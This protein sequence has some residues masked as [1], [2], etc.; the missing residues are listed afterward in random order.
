M[1]DSP[2]NDRSLLHREG[3]AIGFLL[4]A[5][6]L[7]YFP[8]LFGNKTVFSSDTAFFNFPMYETL[9]RALHEGFIPFWEP[10]Q[11]LGLPFMAVLQSSVFYPPSLIFVLDDFTF[12]FNLSLM[13]H[14]GVLVIGVY[15]LMRSWGHSPVASVGSGLTVLMGGFFLSLIDFCNHFHAL[16]WFPWFMLCFDQLLKERSVRFFVLSIVVCV[17]QT[18]AGSPEFSILST[19]LIFAHALFVRRETGGEI[20]KPTL[21]MAGVVLGALAISALQLLP[22]YLFTQ[23]STRSLHLDYANHARWSLAPAGLMQL[24]YA[25]TPEALSRQFQTLGKVS[26]I[27]ATYLGILPAFSLIAAVFFIKTHRAI[28][29]WWIAFWTGLFFALGQFNPLYS[30]FY[31]TMP[32]LSKFRFPEKFLFVCAF[33]MTFLVGMLTDALL[34]TPERTKPLLGIL[35][36]VAVM[37]GIGYAVQPDAKSFLPLVFLALF[38]LVCLLS[39]SGRLTPALFGGLTAFI[40]LTDLMAHNQMLMALTDRRFFDEVPPV[41]KTLAEDPAPF[42]IYS[43][44]YIADDPDDPAKQL[45]QPLRL[46]YSDQKNLLNGPIASLYGQQTIQGTFGVETRDQGLFS[47]LTYKLPIR[48]KLRLLEKFNVRYTITG[49]QW[50]AGPGGALINPTAKATKLNALP[51]AYLVPASQMVEPNRSIATYLSPTFDPRERVLV[52]RPMAAEVDPAF[53]GEVKALRYLPNRVELDTRQTGN[54]FLVLMDGF[55]PGWHATV[56]GQE[57][58]ILRGNHFFRTLPLTGGKHQVVF[59][60]EQEGFRTGV[61]ISL[62]AFI[63]LTV[64]CLGYWL[65]RQKTSA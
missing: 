23:E 59:Y 28:R 49:H 14:H 53:Q 21:L 31:E 63:L 22:T 5:L 9:H 57:V 12:A 25:I 7:L 19:L 13:F 65:F 64:G 11:F 48:D 4:L 44:A 38:G 45:R 34:A 41:V 3:K 43:Q 18:L 30:Y 47:N 6:L 56:D 10:N 52:D 33:G 54:G 32:L 26:F 60:Y 2:L 15:A 35:V 8:V 62:S 55:Y 16:A 20:F 37:G 29:F 39:L 51:R 24:F 17:L 58:E 40:I 46:N 36:A 61:W 1:P 42:R 27:N 50:Q